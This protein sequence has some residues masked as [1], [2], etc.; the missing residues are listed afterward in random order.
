MKKLKNIFLKKIGPGIITGASD[1]DPSGIVT[2]SIAGARG[3]LDFIWTA[4]FTFPLMYYVQEACARIALVTKKSLIYLI[5]KFY[6]VKIAFLIALWMFLANTFNLAAD[7]NALA[8][9]F[10]YIFPYIP[11]W[12]YSLLSS[13]FISLFII[14]LPYK[15]IANF[16][17][18]FV[19]FLFFYL[20]LVFVIDIN[21]QEVLQKIIFPE[22]KLTKDWLLIFIAILGTTISPYLFFWQEEEELEEIRKEKNINLKKELSI[23]KFD[24]ALGMFISNL[25]MFFIIL[26]TGAILN[27]IGIYD[28]EKLE[29]LIKVLEP[30]VGK[31]AFLV[32]SLGI[33]GS[34]L[35]AIPV[36]AAGAAYILSDF[37]NL[38]ATLDKKFKEAFL[39][40]SFIIFSIL[41]SN[42]FNFFGLSPIKLLFYTAVI[43][44]F[45]SPLLIFFILRFSNNQQ[46]MG[47]YK[48]KNI[49]NFV[50]FLTF[51]IMFISSIIF[52]FNF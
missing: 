42:I 21:W 40:Y 15:K 32:F 19:I 31:Y 47:E 14:I 48:N 20:A 28:I 9:I 38:P 26:T 7:I 41:L 51:L 35:I 23:A 27:P 36:L 29:D 25:I 49:S 16:L 52:L 3:G 50:L 5:K 11:I 12:F 17:K 30:L 43:Y 8:M 2:Y 13:I 34:S 1:D 6:G 46:L 33:I 22:I 18:F 37:F 24:T 44:G 4:I 45:L 39:F 10:N